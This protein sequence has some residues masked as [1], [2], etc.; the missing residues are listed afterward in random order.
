MSN[1]PEHPPTAAAVLPLSAAERRA[2]RARAHSLSPTV[3]IGESGLT[4]AIVSETNRA[5][6]AHGLIKV[7]I[8][9]DDRTVRE[10]FAD[11]LCERLGCAFIQSIGKLLVLWRPSNQDERKA[12]TLRK[13]RDT[14]KKL[15]A[16]GKTAPRR[17]HRSPPPRDA[18]APAKPAPRIPGLARRAGPGIRT[19][20][21]ALDPNARPRQFNTTQAQ[22][23]SS[24]PARTES[25]SRNSPSNVPM[26]PPRRTVAGKPAPRPTSAR[27]STPQRTRS[28][29]TRNARPGPRT[30]ARR[31]GH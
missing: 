29:T 21:G 12:A 1:V 3:M 19:A 9:G 18:V 8:F 2:L 14:P 30:R 10:A 28:A 24:R 4:E 20:R 16:A 6:N 11:T 15:A 25:R 23:P 17:K 22:A 31:P 7:R 27:P 13:S 5:L 26:T